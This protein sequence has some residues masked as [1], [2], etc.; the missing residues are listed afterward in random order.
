MITQKVQVG[1]PPCRYR[2]LWLK[3]RCLV[4]WLAGC[5]IICRGRPVSFHWRVR[6]CV[7]ARVFVLQTPCPRTRVWD[8]FS[9]PP[10]FFSTYLS[11]LGKKWFICRSNWGFKL[12]PRHCDHRNED[13]SL[14]LL[15]GVA[16]VALFWGEMILNVYLE[17]PNW[18]LLWSRS[19]LTLWFNKRR[20]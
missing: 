4:G 19:R 16:S 17:R 3:V 5:R 8:C 12:C 11:L 1:K 14:P 7:W 10:I 15:G 18:V 2:W 9:P 20:Q 6:E 13:F